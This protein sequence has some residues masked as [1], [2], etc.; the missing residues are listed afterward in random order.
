[1]L[2]EASESRYFML[3][4][5]GTPSIF[6]RFRLGNH[7]RR[8]LQLI[9]SRRILFAGAYKLVPAPF[10]S[11]DRASERVLRRSVLP[12][13]GGAR[14]CSAVLSSPQRPHRSCKGPLDMA[15]IKYKIFQKPRFVARMVRKLEMGAEHPI[16]TPHLGLYSPPKHAP[17]TP[18]TIPENRHNIS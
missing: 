17:S 6:H 3:L 16:S 18:P 13:L 7:R 12:C 4:P 10:S 8:P 9:K 1:M 15:L 14:T 2:F 11:S 5:I